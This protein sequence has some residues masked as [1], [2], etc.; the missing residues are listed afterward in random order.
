M[1]SFV[2][3]HILGGSPFSS[4][5]YKEV[6]EARGLAYS[7]Y[8]GVL[9]LD[10]ASIFMSS[11]GTRADRSGQ[12]LE[13][14]QDEFRK[15]AETGPTEDEL[16]KAKSYLTGSYGLRF[17]TSTKIAEQLVGIQLEDLGIDYIEKR[18]GLVNAV[19]MDDVKRAA[20]RLLDSK[21]LVAVV[22]KTGTETAKGG[23]EQSHR[24]GAAAV[25]PR[26]AGAGN[27]P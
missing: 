4:R 22:G 26:P 13:V 1:A 11:T 25:A 3:N 14:M 9:P 19:T 24:P 10:H 23:G 18:N 12:T 8:S 16:A 21:M 5:L 27:Q 15:L 20:K 6:R 17:D 2:L 7:V